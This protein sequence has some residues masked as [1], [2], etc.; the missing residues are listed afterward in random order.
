AEEYSDAVRL[1]H[2]TCGEGCSLLTLAFTVIQGTTAEAA[3]IETAL[4]SWLEQL[5]G[6]T[7]RQREHYSR[8][9]NR[10]F[11]RLAPLD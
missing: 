3:A 4:F 5:T 2:A 11:D 10:A 1:I 8:L 7:E 6:L 9:A